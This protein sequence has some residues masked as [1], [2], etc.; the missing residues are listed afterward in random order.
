[1]KTYTIF[2]ALGEINT[3][4]PFLNLDMLTGISYDGSKRDIFIIS[5]AT[6][7]YRINLDDFTYKYLG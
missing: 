5:F 4:A 6:G 1:M 3:V 7:S 2:E